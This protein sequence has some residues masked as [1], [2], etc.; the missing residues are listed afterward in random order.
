MNLLFI[1]LTSALMS[2]SIVPYDEIEKAFEA[3]DSHAISLMGKDKVLFN[4]LGKE[5]VYSQP[6]ASLV[7]ND[8][9]KRKPG[10]SF[11]FFFKGKASSKGSFAIGKYKSRGSEFRVTIHFKKITSSF[12]IESLTIEAL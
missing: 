8:F 12:K 1:F 9:F 10:A 3:N 5:G 6:Q 7:L 4:I 2:L 11:K